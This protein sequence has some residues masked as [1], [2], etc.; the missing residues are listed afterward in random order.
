MF[1]ANVNAFFDITIS[2]DLVNDDAHSMRGY[3]INNSGPSGR[4]IKKVSCLRS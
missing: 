4:C 2:N 1:H 3:I